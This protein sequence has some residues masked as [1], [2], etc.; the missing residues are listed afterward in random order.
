MSFKI[1]FTAEAENE[2]KRIIENTPVQKEAPV[3]K[4]SVVEVFSPTGI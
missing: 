2:D 3:I 1:G 4:K